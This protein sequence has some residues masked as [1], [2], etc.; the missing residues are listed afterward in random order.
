M[1]E[2]SDEQK[3]MTSDVI[4]GEL[5]TYLKSIDLSFRSRDLKI[6]PQDTRKKVMFNTET[7]NI[8]ADFVILE[9]CKPPYDPPSITLVSALAGNQTY[10]LS[11]IASIQNHLKNI[12]LPR[13]KNSELE[14]LKKL[15]EIVEKII[16]KME[17]KGT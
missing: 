10:H 4:N 9:G 7:L 11:D 15:T 12:I 5:E 17:P 14:A 16:D 6:L 3:T 2:V 13:K 1:P 8:I